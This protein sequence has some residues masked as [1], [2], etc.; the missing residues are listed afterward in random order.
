MTK[1]NF[2]PSLKKRKG[3]QP[4]RLESRAQGPHRS[5][6]KSGLVGVIMKIS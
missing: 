4:P 1:W 3:L 2:F 5:D 6:G